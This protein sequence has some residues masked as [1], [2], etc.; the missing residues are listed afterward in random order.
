MNN[1][2]NF[3]Y[4]DLN[5][6]L[7]KN[8]YKSF[9]YLMEDEHKE[10]KLNYSLS[11]SMFGIKIFSTL[12]V[13]FVDT[14]GHYYP[15]EN[16]DYIKSCGVLYD[17]DL[18][19]SDKLSYSF[20]S[21]IL[22]SFLILEEKDIDSKDNYTTLSDL[23]AISEKKLVEIEI[24]SLCED[25]N[26]E[27]EYLFFKNI[28]KHIEDNKHFFYETTMNVVGYKNLIELKHSLYGYVDKLYELYSEQNNGNNSIFLDDNENNDIYTN[29]LLSIMKNITELEIYQEQKK[30]TKKYKKLNNVLLKN[31]I[32]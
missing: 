31:V 25:N 30:I 28:Y 29:N 18:V 14:E 7:S 19:D 11:I 27:K 22:N 2:I 32:I 23:K 20:N 6:S 9:F 12:S 24:E 15:K 16:T 1:E 10:N 8:K 5:V 21:K 3:K 13:E 17:E 26:N 4:K